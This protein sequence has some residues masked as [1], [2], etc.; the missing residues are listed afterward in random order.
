MSN[1]EGLA[2]GPRAW[3]LLGL[4]VV[5]GAGPREQ[6]APP[7]LVVMLVVDQMRAD[8]LTRFQSHYTGGFARLMKHGAVFTD[9]H[10]E[11]FFT[12]TAPGHATIATGV[13]PSRHGIVS[14]DW[15]DRTERKWVYAV[16]DTAA[17]IVGAPDFPGRSP[18]NLWRE[19]V[20]DWLKRQ[21]PESKVYAVALKD[22]ASIVLGGQHPDG[23]YWF[24]PSSGAFVTST[25][26]RASLPD[27]VLEF[28][29]S[30]RVD[31][32]AS[33]VWTRVLAEEMYAESR[34]DNFP[35]ENDGIHVTFPHALP[36]Y[37]DS[38]PP[39]PGESY[40]RELIRT[41]FG[42]E[43]TLAFVEQLILNEGVGDDAAPDLLFVSASSADYIG[44][45]YGP[46]SQEIQD[47]YLRFDRA[48]GEFLE[49][50]DEQIGRES[51]VVVLSS[52]HGVLP[53]PEE[54]LRRGTDARRLD[55]LDR[56]ELI[57]TPLLEAMDSLGI[58]AN[59][60]VLSLLYGLVMDFPEEAVSE[61]EMAELRRVTAAS[62]L[63][64][65][66]VAD[67]YA[68]DDVDL[69]TTDEF[70]QRHLRSFHPNRAS[71]IIIRFKER[72][73][74][75][76]DFGTTHETP[77]PYDTHVPLI[78]ARPGTASAWYDRRVATVDIA[79]TLAALLAITAPADLDGVALREIVY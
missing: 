4:L 11:H 39:F 22:R 52:D 28:N 72:Y 16:D 62:I 50:L 24:N 49:F 59:P 61:D 38:T 63:A 2:A 47:Y 53:M 1:T 12:S 55:A 27:W 60:R 71:D 3:L 21:V 6:A 17:L 74:L 42:D 10:H 54:L 35:P 34:E 7:K 36:G 15:W 13:H 18:A 5:A 26:Y 57:V 19:G 76:G 20:G 66:L 70:R 46:Y 43:L 67:A 8:Y 40:Y 68:I 48:L 41:P 30:G 79:P 23:V 73:L 56:Q 44:H 45:R 64:S 9:A 14:N 32:H 33:G 58:N 51:Y 31:A 69:A 37:S 29:R 25:Y 75:Y 78:V 77:Y 65:N